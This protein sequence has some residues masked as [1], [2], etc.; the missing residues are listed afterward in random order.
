M[1]A[2]YAFARRADD[3]GDGS[4]AREEKLRRLE[5]LDAALGALAEAAKPPPIR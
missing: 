5:Q 3:I 2:V 1:S 4:L